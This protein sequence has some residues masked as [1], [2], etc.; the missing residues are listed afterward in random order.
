MNLASSISVIWQPQP[1]PQT[2]LV[3]CPVTE[4]F[5]GGARGGG[6][7]DSSLG[8]WL[9]HSD[10][11]KQ[12]AIGVF[13]RRKFKQLEEVIARAK[14]LF[15][16]LGAKYNE[17][18]AEFTM[19]GGAR[20]KFRYL[21]R[22]S[23]AEEY[24]GHAYTR[25]YIEEATN[26]PSAKPINLLRGTLRPTHPGIPCGMR[27]TG[28]PG[29][30]GHHWVKE[31][32]IAP[33]PAGYE[34]LW[35]EFTSPFDG[36][37]IRMD[38]VFIPSKLTDNRKLLDGDPMYVGRLHQAGSAALVKAW[39]EGNWDIIDGVFFDNFDSEV[40]V[41]TQA[42]KRDRRIIVPENALRFGAFDWGSAKPFSMGW[43]AVSDGR[44]GLPAGALFK[45]REWYGSTGK[46][47][48]GLRLTCEQIADGILAREG[49][50]TRSQELV[51]Y[52]AADPAVFKQDGGPSQAERMLIR[53][54][55]MQRADNSR[56]TGWDQVRHRLNGE[57]DELGIP[58]GEPMLYFDESCEDTIRTFESLQ[59]D[60][61]KPEDC[62]TEQEDHA[63]DE[64]R[65]GC[66][67]RPWVPKILIP[68]E[69]R[70]TNDVSTMNMNQL[71]ALAGK[72]RRARENA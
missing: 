59:T 28:N 13:F 32:Y 63:A 1:G 50:R 3:T 56:V 69:R 27:L 17:S 72:Q 55:G 15:K 46:S 41:L 22:D 49:W 25:I 70:V 39:L 14:T 71:V 20:L 31:R 54:C 35:E 53:G 21:E 24:Q 38:R 16:P 11:Y 42:M 23:D 67:S 37:T 47:N 29:G 26:F 64:T 68:S 7:T 33:N 12:Y 61:D 18:K 8:D 44:W 66:M 65:Y 5:F 45:Y 48:E 40:H 36:S 57:V 58:L 4:V 43:Y 34:V 51:R 60:E 52:R 9:L 30:P 6:K 19:P 10:M 62:D 2:A